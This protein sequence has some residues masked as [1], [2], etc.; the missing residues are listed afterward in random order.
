VPIFDKLDGAGN[1][2]GDLVSSQNEA[3]KSGSSMNKGYF[4]P[5]SLLWIVAVPRA[6]GQVVLTGEQSDKDYCYRIE[7]IRPNLELR[8]SVHIV[9]RITD[10]HGAPLMKSRVELRKYLSERKQTTV[11]A[12]T[13]DGNGYFDMGTVEGGKYRFLASPNRGFQQP[14]SL[15][16]SDKK[17]ELNIALKV[18]P[19]DLPV[20]ACPI[21]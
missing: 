2:G 21:R 11:K 3:G 5:L 1:M 9:G 20:S 12:T 18:N 14:T 16:C 13:T 7:T 10:D 6:F 19:T 8:E 17:C 4:L 15:K